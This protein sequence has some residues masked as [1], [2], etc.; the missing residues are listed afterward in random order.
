M[1]LREELDDL[2][3]FEATGSEL[4]QRMFKEKG[5]L[6]PVT[7]STDIREVLGALIALIRGLHAGIERL[8]DEV[9]ALKLNAGES[10]PE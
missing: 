6:G 4:A 9:T 10:K 3:F 2:M 1:S 8:A 5:E 7:P